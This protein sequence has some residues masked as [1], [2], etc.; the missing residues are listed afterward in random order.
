MYSQLGDFN[1]FPI[2]ALNINVF[3]TL[4]RTRFQ[5]C[6]SLSFAPIY[7]TNTDLTHLSFTKGYVL[8]LQGLGAH[9]AAGMDGKQGPQGMLTGSRVRGCQQN[10]S[11]PNLS[12]FLEPLGQKA[13]QGF[14]LSFKIRFESVMENVGFFACSHGRK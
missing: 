11:K 1:Q 4:Y 12:L 14:I 8:R 5:I 3:L 6:F 7:Y 10:I 2:I 9:M 13:D